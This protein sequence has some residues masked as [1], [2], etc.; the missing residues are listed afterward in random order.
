MKPLRSKSLSLMPISKEYASSFVD[1]LR[2]RGRPADHLSGLAAV[3]EDTDPT[4]RPT[5]SELARL[6]PPSQESNALLAAGTA[7]GAA[8]LIAEDFPGPSIL[9]YGAALNVIGIA[10]QTELQDSISRAEQAIDKA[11]LLADGDVKLLVA[12]ARERARFDKVTQMLKQEFTQG[13]QASGT[14]S[15]SEIDDVVPKIVSVTHDVRHKGLIERIEWANTYMSVGGSSTDAGYLIKLDEIEF[16]DDKLRALLPY[17][18]VGCAFSIA[19]RLQE[20][21]RNAFGSSPS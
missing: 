3:A 16:K 9:L 21:R 1:D 8:K 2:F 10:P 4:W 15:A 7:Y 12:A 6:L 18:K 5:V 11:G 19:K 13:L 14:Y 20:R 17:A